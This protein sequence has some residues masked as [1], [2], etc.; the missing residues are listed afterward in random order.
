MR[1]ML[2]PGG[3]GLRLLMPA[4]MLCDQSRTNQP[5]L[6][7]RSHA[8]IEADFLRNLAV[9]DAQHRCAG[10]VHLAARCRSQRSEP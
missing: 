4:P 2:T 5:E 3:P 10:E 1:R 6:L 7:E 9:L 8:V